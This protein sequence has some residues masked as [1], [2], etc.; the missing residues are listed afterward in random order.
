M[1]D[2]LRSIEA[3]RIPAPAPIEQRWSAASSSPLSPAH[4]PREEDIFAWVGII[5]YLA[6][7]DPEVRDAITH[8][9]G[10]ACTHPLQGRCGMPMLWARLSTPS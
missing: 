8:R 4:S 7:D 1:T 9:W 2:L 6:S 3:A 10:H 5:M